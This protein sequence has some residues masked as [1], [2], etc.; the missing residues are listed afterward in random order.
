MLGWNDVFYWWVQCAQPSC[1]LAIGSCCYYTL[2]YVS[3]CQLLKLIDDDDDD[4]MYFT[5]LLITKWH[6][7]CHLL[8]SPEERKTE[9]IYFLK[10]SR[11][12]R[13]GQRQV[14][15]ASLNWIPSVATTQILKSRCRLILRFHFFSEQKLNSITACVV[16]QR[17]I[18]RLLWRFLHCVGLKSGPQNN[19]L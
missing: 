14:L 5:Y 10:S 17:L 1:A 18:Y 4:G 11:C 16:C 9:Q 7:R 6:D 3:L 8:S 15:I 13:D 2:H 19:L 12:I